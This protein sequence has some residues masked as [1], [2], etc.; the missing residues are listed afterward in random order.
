MTDLGPG[1][2]RPDLFLALAL[3][4]TTPGIRSA[5]AVSMLRMRPLAMA[6]V[7]T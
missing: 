6:A 3:R 1:E 7:T 4:R 2:E 5:A